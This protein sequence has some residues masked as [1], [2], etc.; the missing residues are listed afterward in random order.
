VLAASFERCEKQQDAHLA[1][2]TPRI[3]PDRELSPRTFSGYK[4]TTDGLVATFGNDG[5]VDDLA[6]EDF[7]GRRA[8]LAK[9]YGR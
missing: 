8:T 9:P 4:D 3:E 5:L 7:A 6:D 1:G 2:R